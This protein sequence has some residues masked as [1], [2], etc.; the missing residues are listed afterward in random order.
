MKYYV[1]Y[2]IV[3]WFQAS[4]LVL[5]PRGVISKVYIIFPKYIVSQLPT[6]ELICDFSTHIWN[7]MRSYYGSSL[8]VWHF[9]SIFNFGDLCT[10][11]SKS[12]INL[13]NKLITLFHLQK[14][15]FS[16]TFCFLVSQFFIYSK[17]DTTS[18][19]LPDWWQLSWLLTVFHQHSLSY[20]GENIM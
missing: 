7:L 18:T 4:F 19:S 12:L 13:L 9:T 20:Q 17:T 3:Y 5:R 14:Q 11:Q 10:L 8:S 6:L 1:F 2:N 15:L 16:S